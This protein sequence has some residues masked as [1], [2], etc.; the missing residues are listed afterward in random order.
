MPLTYVNAIS[1]DFEVPQI[2]EGNYELKL[3]FTPFPTQVKTGCL[4]FGVQV[5]DPSASNTYTSWI[6]ATLVGVAQFGTSDYAS[7]QPEEP[8]QVCLAFELV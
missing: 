2:P 3:S 4:V 7:R 6:S 1:F 5:V 8:V